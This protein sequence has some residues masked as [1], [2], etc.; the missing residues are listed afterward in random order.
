MIQDTYNNLKQELEHKRLIIFGCGVHFQRFCKTYISL[1]DKIEIILDNYCDK[2]SVYLENINKSIPVVRPEKIKDWSMDRYAVLFCC[3]AGERRA[4][5][6]AQLTAIH[7]QGGYKKFF[8]PIYE[9]YDIFGRQNMK[10]FIVEH[11]E[12]LVDYF[13]LH[14]RILQ[15][16]SKETLPELMDEIYARKKVVVPE[17]V[18]ILT[19][20]CTLRCKNCMNLMWAF[21]EKVIDVPLEETC[22]SLCRILEAVDCVVTVSVIGGEPFLADSFAGLM[23]FLQE[24]QKVLSIYITTNGTVPI[25]DEWVPLLN[26]DNVEVR[27]SSYEHIVNQDR[28]VESCVANGIKY[29]REST[30]LWID[31]G[32]MEQ[33]NCGEDKLRLQYESCIFAKRCKT[34]WGDSLYAC[35][36]SGSLEELGRVSGIS[37]KISESTDLRNDLLEFLLTPNIK[38]CDF[39]EADFADLKFVPVAEQIER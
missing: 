37:L 17:I 23:R 35:Q 34:M 4:A 11:I 7:P 32:S 16:C 5:M 8:T 14:D 6:E 20:R 33:R 38:A 12:K 10:N 29:S 9:G 22:E 13:D 25:K 2:E 21:Q 3:R 19:S 39:C 27:I 26:Q 24:Q 15:V 36:V 1:L 30:D 31:F 18:V 28:F